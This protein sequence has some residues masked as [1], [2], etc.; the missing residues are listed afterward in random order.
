MI[1]TA[2]MTGRADDLIDALLTVTRGEVLR[3]PS[4]ENRDGRGGEYDG[5]LQGL[6]RRDVRRLTAAGLISS[7]GLPAD[8]LA[9]HAGSLENADVFAAWYCRQA[10]AG[11]DGRAEHRAGGPAERDEW[12]DNHPSPNVELPSAL[13]DYLLRLV[14]ERKADYAGDVADA[15]ICGAP[16]PS[17]DARW[18][19]DV[20]R[21]VRRYLRP[22]LGP[23]R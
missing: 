2:T 6:S 18:A 9:H 16:V 8:R 3:P 21:K 7:H 17:C 5:Y 22:V 4:A 13:T 23:V 19:D 11:L 15:L 1:G 12:D 20:V 10:L 14:C